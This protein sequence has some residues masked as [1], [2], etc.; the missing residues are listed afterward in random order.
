MTTSIRGEWGHYKSSPKE[1]S[2]NIKCNVMCSI[3]FIRQ[4]NPKQVSGTLLSVGRMLVSHA[5]VYRLPYPN[6]TIVLKPVRDLAE[7][8]VAINKCLAERQS[9]RLF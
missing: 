9:K 3:S 5:K 2:N 8:E 1:E 6:T 4:F 7:L